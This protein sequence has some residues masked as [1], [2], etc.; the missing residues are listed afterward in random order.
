MRVTHTHTHTR[1]GRQKAK[2]IISLSPSLHFPLPHIRLCCCFS[3]L[4]FSCF[5][6]T[7]FYFHV[8][9]LVVL[10]AL[11]S[12]ACFASPSSRFLLV[13]LLKRSIH[14]FYVCVCI[15]LCTHTHT[16][17]CMYTYIYL[18]VISFMHMCQ[19]AQSQDL[20][21]APFRC[22]TPK[23]C[24]LILQLALVKRVQRFLLS[25]CACLC[26][27]QHRFN[28]NMF[29]IVYTHIH[30]Y[31]CMYMFGLRLR[32]GF[33]SN[34]KHFNFNFCY[35][36]FLFSFDF[37]LQYLLVKIYFRTEQQQEFCLRSVWM[38]IFV[39]ICCCCCQC[40]CRCFDGGGG[41]WTIVGH[42]GFNSLYMSKLYYKC[43]FM[44]P[45]GFIFCFGY[46]L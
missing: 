31:I 4:V 11:V 6:F 38:L 27:T 16:H 36:L 35:I 29:G 34:W 22:T 10:L 21:L 42:S 8:R 13:F 26:F 19:C 23:K 14:S 30:T 41:R 3:L 17:M 39:C 2:R 46:F 45:N 20:H 5:Y 15:R 32:N 25:Q 33:P 1:I 7:F 44:Q 40:C 9:A 28:C 12:A 18:Y 43:T 24:S 37:F